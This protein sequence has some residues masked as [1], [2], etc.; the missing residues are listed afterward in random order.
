MSLT[1]KNGTFELPP[2][3]VQVTAELHSALPRTG[4]CLWWTAGLLLWVCVTAGLQPAFPIAVGLPS[5]VGS[6]DGP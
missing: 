6:V 4:V 1:V 2:G 3:C 5:V